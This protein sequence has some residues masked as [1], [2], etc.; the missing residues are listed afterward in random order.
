M[1]STLGPKD[2]SISS[3]SSPR[4]QSEGVSGNDQSTVLPTVLYHSLMDAQRQIRLLQILPETEDQTRPLRCRLQNFSLDDLNSSFQ[5]TNL[6]LGSSARQQWAAFR[7]SEQLASLEALR[8]THSTRPAVELYRF[9]WGDFAALSYVWGDT[10]DDRTIIVNDRIV[11]IR[12]NL[13]VALRAFRDKCEF[14][15]RFMLWVDAICINQDDLDERSRQIKMMRDI[16]ASAWSVVAWLGPE[17]HHSDSAIQLIQDFANFKAEGC[18]DQIASSLEANPQFCGTIPW[19]ALQDLMDRPYF[20]RLWIIQEVIMGSES[21]WVRC[22]K[23]VIEWTK[24]CA[25]IAVLQEHL[26]L[27]KDRCLQTALST[28]RNYVQRAWRTGSLHLVYQDLSVLSKREAKDRSAFG[29]ERL[30]DPANSSDCTDKRDKVYALL[31][32][33]HP[34]VAHH[35]L[36]NY[37]L[38]E[39]KVYRDAARAFIE[40]DNSLDALR[41]GNPWGS[42]LCPSWAADWSWPGRIRWS[43]TGQKVWGPVYLFPQ[44]EDCVYDTQY[45]ASARLEHSVSF[46]DDGS[47]LCCN[48]IVVDSVSGLSARNKGYFSWSQETI[49]RPSRWQ[50]TYGGFDDTAKALYRTL[51]CDRVAYGRRSGPQHAAIFHL[52]SNF[53]LGG[54]Q[55]RARKWVFLAG[56]EGYYFRWA[57]FRTNMR[58]FP[59]GEHLFDDFFSDQI[60]ENASEFVFT[61]AYSCFDRSCKKRRFITTTNGYMGWAPD[62][63]YGS[64]DEQTRQGD[65]IAI[66]FGCSTPLVLRPRG[67]HYQVLGEAY[68]QGFMDGEAITA[69]KEGKYARQEFLLC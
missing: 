55:F 4:P 1:T 62:N 37:T 38:P 57:Q 25:G 5:N 7:M 2:F 21:T 12:A 22:G 26:W 48:G 27:V 32:L 52:P 35:L 36:P 43:R 51:V 14:G 69:L 44:N 66:I 64:D 59:L 41:E 49:V 65:L 16:Y 24:F 47:L 30:L 10:A 53:F 3:W 46:H 42:E 9:V 28:G 39:W 17:S 50:S 15:D 31:G 68:V 19:I 23:A 58:G 13:D 29:F 18:I 45:Q 8:R 34:S 61:E 20:F 6:D 56:Q 11:Y 67:D 40:V 54:P 63:I 60:P 33:V